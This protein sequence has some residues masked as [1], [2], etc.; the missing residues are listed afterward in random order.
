M[1][2]ELQRAVDILNKQG[3]PVH[4]IALSDASLEDIFLLLT[5]KE[6]RE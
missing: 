1:L 4:N 3:Y 6:V 5:G 2:G